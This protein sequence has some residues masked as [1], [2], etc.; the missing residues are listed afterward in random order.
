MGRGLL[1]FKGKFQNKLNK[2]KKVVKAKLDKQ[3]D[4]E[5]GYYKAIPEVEQKSKK[6]RI[7]H[8]P[9]PGSGR[10][11]SSGPVV[12]GRDS[13]F[14]SE[15]QSGDVLV[16]LVDAMNFVKESRTVLRV[17]SDVNLSIN[18]PFSKDVITWSQ[19]DIKKRDE[20]EED[21]STVDQ[22]YSKK[23]RNT[24]D[25]EPEKQFIEI[26]EKVGMWGYKTRKV[27]IDPGMTMEEK[28]RL[29]EKYKKDKSQWN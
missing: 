25:L 22:L 8:L 28:M 29:K 26:R 24:K 1:K 16:V 27:E 13:K 5:E 3:K 20:E 17:V 12:M 10:V 6:K 18:K 19:Y 15:V 11:L 23:M 4:K 2:E 21:D 7:E 14:K 9:V